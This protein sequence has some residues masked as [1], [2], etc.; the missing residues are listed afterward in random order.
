MQGS[1]HVFN[2][3]HNNNINEQNDFMIDNNTIIDNNT[4]ENNINNEQFFRTILAILW[5]IS[6]DKNKISSYENRFTC[7]VE[8]TKRITSK[9]KLQNRIGI[10]YRNF[11]NTSF[12]PSVGVLNITLITKIGVTF[13]LLFNLL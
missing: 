5:Y 9:I 12:A 13:L 1:N 3:I 4:W 10:E 8:L 6:N 2:N 7:A 11:I